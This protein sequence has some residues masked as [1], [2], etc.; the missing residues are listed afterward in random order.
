[1]SETQTNPALAAAENYEKNVVT[2]TTAPFAGILLEHAAP[3]PGEHVVDIACGTGVVA[4]LAAPLVRESGVVV[5]VDVNPA[6][7]AV[8]RSLP[9]PIGAAIDWKEGNALSLPLPDNC[10]DLALCQF[11]LQFIPDRPGALGE[12]YRVLKPGGRVAISVMGSV[13]KNPVQNFIWGTIARHLETPLDNLNPAFSLGDIGLLSSLLEGSGFS[14]VTIL[15]R[16]YTIRQPRNPNLIMNIFAS[17]AGVLPKFAA[18]DEEARTAL[19]QAIEAEI[20]PAQQKY[21]EGDEELYPT[22][23]NIAI[24]RKL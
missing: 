12:M 10:F 2:Y 24:G 17:L 18:L 1:V 21:I 20:S 22:I 5:G 8:A 23:A 15:D 19:A 9:A 6:M 4:R 16:F 11:G 3:Q 13:E 14:D 7:I